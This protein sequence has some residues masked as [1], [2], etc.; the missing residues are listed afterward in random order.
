MLQ[1][2]STNHIADNI[3][4]CESDSSPYFLTRTFKPDELSYIIALII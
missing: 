1:T 3:H 2:L 4:V